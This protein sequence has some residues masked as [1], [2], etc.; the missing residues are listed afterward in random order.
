MSET[1]RSHAAMMRRKRAFADLH[2]LDEGRFVDMPRILVDSA[3]LV[4][5]AGR[6][7]NSFLQPW[8]DARRNVA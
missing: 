6:A 2:A 1:Q 8:Q 4:A 3:K 7:L 5:W